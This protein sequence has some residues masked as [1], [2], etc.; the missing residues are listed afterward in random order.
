MEP[1]KSLKPADGSGVLELPPGARRLGDPRMRCPGGIKA[2]QFAPNGKTLVSASWGELRGWDPATGRVMWRLAF[3]SEATVDSGRLTSRNTFILLCRPNSGGSNEL[4]QYDFGTGKLVSRAKGLKFD[5]SQRN[6][7]S[8]DGTL[9]VVVHDNSL[10][11]HDS[12]TGT[13]KWKEST[14]AENV[15]DCLFFPDGKTIAVAGRGEVRL[16]SV[17]DGKQ[18]GTF[19]VPAQKKEVGNA[20]PNGRDRDHVS[21]LVVSSDGKLLAASIGEE[22]DT[23]VCWDVAS[24]SLKQTLKPAGKPLGFA[25]DTSELATL[26]HGAITFWTLATGKR[27]RKFS[28]PKDDTYLSPDGKTIAVGTPDAI[29]LIDAT[30]GKPLLHSAD[31]PGVPTTLAFRGPKRLL[32]R[33]DPWGGWVEWDLKTGR[34]TLV[35]PPDV[36]G[37]DPISLSTDGQVA[38]YRTFKAGDD[39]A[40]FTARAVADGKIVRSA[41]APVEANVGVVTLAMT[42][43]G[44][45]LVTPTPQGLAV[46]TGDG[47]R[48]IPCK[49][50]PVGRVAVVATD[51]KTVAVGRANEGERGSIDLYDLPGDQ[52]LR[53]MTTEG[54]VQRIDLSPD[55][56]RLVVAHDTEGGGGR[57]FSASYTA[58]VFDLRTGKAVFRA[59]PIPREKDPLVALSPT[60]RLIA[61]L[62]HDGTIALFELWS[63]E[64]RMRLEIAKDPTVNALAFSP[65]GRTLAV[66]V[67]GGPVLLWDLY[68]GPA[69]VLSELDLDRA[70]R[71]LAGESAEARLAWI[72]ILTNAGPFAAIRWLVGSPK[73]ALTYLRKKLPPTVGPDPKVVAGYIADLDH[74][75]FRKRE[76][77]VRELSGLGEHAH[78]A[79]VQALGAKPS[80]ES[81]ERI[82]K[83]LAAEGR[84]GP[85]QLRRLRAV[86]AVEMIGTPEAAELLDHWAGGSAGVF[87][88]EAQVAA[89]RLAVRDS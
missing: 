48:V 2:L 21:D 55:G 69:K 20:P 28:V 33:L 36:D 42:P 26:Y 31:P 6:A 29:V 14:P 52:F 25:P 77:A 86:E 44:R 59:E 68:A 70:W 73:E 15:V 4:R 47:P 49:L 17:A 63:G 27:A 10:S 56:T 3:P 84:P 83:L 60:G 40:D 46:T 57:R 53:R 24:S 22:E 11:L 76:A 23:V 50:E 54:D 64:L 88:S 12:A 78:G 18:S 81:R 34:H 74:V 32:G 79:L 80:P 9:M 30:T 13:E 39:T 71:H 75:Q 89:R 82:E 62:E 38:L 61:R 19:K 1:E 43:D 35:R 37:L 72:G 87:T 58:T 16:F 7:W 67:H 41:K 51:G 85:D 66:S 5:R 8:V 45:T 65:D